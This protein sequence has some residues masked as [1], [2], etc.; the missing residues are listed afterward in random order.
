MKD[1]KLLF[2]A[3]HLERSEDIVHC[4]LKVSI[5][6]KIYHTDTNLCRSEIINLKYLVHDK[7][8]NKVPHRM[9]ASGQSGVL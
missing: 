7:A 4:I 5:S 1:L 3:S 8:V 6:V 9:G 2:M